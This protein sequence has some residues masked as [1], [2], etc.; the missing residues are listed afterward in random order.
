MWSDNETDIDL[1]GFSV[2]ASLVK[3]VIT[4][5]RNLPVTMGLYGDWGS[6]KS[7]VL[8]ILEK[9]ITADSIL[10]DDTIVIYF[11]GWIFEGYDDAK[12]ALMQ[13][14]ITQLI[15]N[16]QISEEAKSVVKQLG[17]KLLCSVNWMRILQWST[18]NVVLPA[19]TA[20]ATGGLS[21]VPFLISKFQE[22]KGHLEDLLTNDKAPNFLNNI[23]ESKLDD[24]KITAVR[25]FREKFKELIAAT[26]KTRLVVL[27]DDLDRCTPRRIIEN[28]E[29]IKLFLN[30][31]KTAF[32][33]A[34]DESIV[35]NAVKSEYSKYSHEAS[36][37]EM[38]DIGSSYMEKLIQIPYKLPRLTHKEAETYISLLFCQSELSK[39]SFE[40]I[41]QDYVNFITSNKFEVY[42]WNN[43]ERR[44]S[45]DDRI[46]IKSTI[47]FVAQ[48]SN[49]IS[50]CLKGNPRLIKRFLNA[51]ELR[52]GLLKV[53]GVEDQKIK[54]SLIKL[55]II[56][57]NY[58]NLF[59]QL[60]DW[61]Q[62]E[63]G[64]PSEI[65]E[66]EKLAFDNADKYPDNLKAWNEPSLKKLVTIRPLFSETDLRDLYWV[67]RDKLSDI[68]GGASLISPKVRAL[69]NDSISASS[70]NIL[71][72][73]YI[74]RMKAL[75]ESELKD[76]YA[77]LDETIM[78]NPH[79]KKGYDIYYFCVIG[80]VELA[81]TQLVNIL[82]RID[83]KNIPVSLSVKLNKIKEKYP[84]DKKFDLILSINE[85]LV[86]AMQLKIYNKK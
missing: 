68:V 54:Q 61:Q 86:R 34:A 20:Y 13:E 48:L 50:N 44:L 67:S 74:P 79:D 66:I 16:K 64:K 62:Q 70:D 65:K 26:G 39:E 15:V 42:G 8:K 60:Y 85:S 56:E 35:S 59:E 28:L 78:A 14:I 2:H 80:D 12:S 4:N 58:T 46:Q 47:S 38:R 24:E 19:A 81:Y 10:K 17:K 71:Q 27:I 76:F 55:M 31:E 43:I 72:Q 51:Y 82:S 7:S 18:K 37:K 5:D 1:L 77:L 83:V 84:G 9:Q 6:G 32:V 63:A 49:M 11:D 45:E 33:I 73:S 69:F 52:I 30:V 25:D 57:Y 53:G 40:N 41:H 75:S 22:N 23:L 21:L 3:D 36:E 29:A